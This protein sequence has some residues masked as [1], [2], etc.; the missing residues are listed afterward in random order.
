VLN[1]LG[2]LIALIV[3][4]LVQ[5]GNLLSFLYERYG[6]FCLLRLL[7][8]LLFVRAVRQEMASSS[9]SSSA[10]SSSSGS[11]RVRRLPAYLEDSALEPPRKKRNTWVSKYDSEIVALS[12]EDRNA[13]DIAKIICTRHDADPAK[14]TSRVIE[15][16]LRYLKRNSIYPFKPVNASMNLR[17][18]D[19]PNSCQY[20][21]AA[22]FEFIFFE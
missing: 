11:S 16:R 13:Q 20:L 2:L 21:Y 5:Y 15:S 8:L 18:M 14:V 6:L 17:A 12:G 1:K 7:L 22:L 19:L 3:F 4:I 9:S 10:S